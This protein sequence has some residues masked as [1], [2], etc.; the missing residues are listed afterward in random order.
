MGPWGWTPPWCLCA[1][2]SGLDTCMADDSAL[3]SP[4]FQLREEEQSGD[5]D[6]MRSSTDSMIKC[7]PSIQY[8]RISCRNV[9]SEQLFSACITTG[10]HMSVLHN[11]LQGWWVCHNPQSGCQ[12]QPVQTY[13]AEGPR[14]NL[15]RFSTTEFSYAVAVQQQQQ[16]AGCQECSQSS[17]SLGL[18]LCSANPAEELCRGLPRGGWINLLG[19]SHTSHTVQR[20][21]ILLLCSPS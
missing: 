4:G 1:D 21:F 19:S 7:W 3:L 6:E 16:F 12:H 10:Q 17:S 5:M 15:H 11:K 13:T 8:E 18:S 14:F 2:L 9:L 20:I